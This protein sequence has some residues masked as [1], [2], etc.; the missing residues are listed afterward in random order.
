LKG[1]SASAKVAAATKRHKLKR[2]AFNIFIPS[3]R[4]F[5]AHYIRVELR[6]Q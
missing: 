1:S 3:G 4:G 5:L 2:F 6:T